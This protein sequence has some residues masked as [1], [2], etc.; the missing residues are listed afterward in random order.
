M[1]ELIFRLWLLSFSCA[2]GVDDAGLLGDRR[3]FGE[4]GFFLDGLLEQLSVLLL[5]FRWLCVD[6]TSGEWFDCILDLKQYSY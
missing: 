5:E 1:L 6:D 3:N 2:G 4:I